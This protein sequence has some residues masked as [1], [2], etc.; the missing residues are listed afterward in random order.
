MYRALQE[1]LLDLIERDDQTMEEK[2]HTFLRLMND[3]LDFMFSTFRNMERMLLY[4]RENLANTAFI[5]EQIL[6]ATPE[7]DPRRDLI[8]KLVEVAQKRL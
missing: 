6:D 5:A 7:S 4:Q 3:R 8:E 1:Q 2:K